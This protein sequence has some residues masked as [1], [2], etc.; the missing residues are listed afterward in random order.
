MSWER[1]NPG[2][3][4][5]IDCDD[6]EPAQDRCQGCGRP[7]CGGCASHTG[8]CEECDEA[9]GNDHHDY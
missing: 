9:L 7:L 1:E 8:K 4:D 2:R 6:T 5:C 3:V